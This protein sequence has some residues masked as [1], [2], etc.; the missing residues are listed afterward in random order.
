MASEARDHVLI[1]TL[2]RVPLQFV[3]SELF[4]KLKAAGFDDLTAAHLVVFQYLPPRG[5]RLTDLAEAAHITKQ[6][7]GYLIDHLEAR[8]YVERQP[9]RT[10]RRSKTIILTDRGR[11]LNRTT[12]Q[13]IRAVEADWEKQLGAERMAALRSALQDLNAYLQASTQDQK[14]KL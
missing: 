12:R 7:M 3:V 2:L 8:G 1:S 13:V 10:D 6:S 5:A 4:R 14:P 9:E 11:A